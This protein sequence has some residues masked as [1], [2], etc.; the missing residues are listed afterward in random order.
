MLNWKP[1]SPSMKEDFPSDCIPTT[2]S[3]G[4]SNMM[5]RLRKE[6]IPISDIEKI[7]F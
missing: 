7:I 6:I 4:V 5:L 2:T 3:S 1:R